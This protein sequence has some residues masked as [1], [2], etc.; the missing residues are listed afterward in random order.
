MAAGNGVLIVGVPGFRLQGFTDILNGYLPIDPG[1]HPVDN[2]LNFFNTQLDTR[3]G[4]RTQDENP[5]LSSAK[6]LLVP[7]VLV[8]RDQEFVA[9][10]F[11]TV[12]QVSVRQIRPSSFIGGID[13]MAGKMAAQGRRR[14]LVKQNL[15]E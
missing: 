9:I 4:S 2:G 14:A 6:I 3:P 8:G 12:K 7:Y 15:H 10:Q 5:Q 1:L 11:R 13:R